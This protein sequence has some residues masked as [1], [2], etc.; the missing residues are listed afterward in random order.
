MSNNIYIGVDLGGTKIAIG[1]VNEA[2][3]AEQKK[4]L[5][6]HTIP[7]VF[8]K[9]GPTSDPAIREAFL[10]NLA[11]EISKVI[12]EA[13]NLKYHVHQ[14][15]GFGSPGLFQDGKIAPET[16]GQLGP[17]FFNYNI[18]EGLEHYLRTKHPHIK[19][20]VKNDALA[21]LAFGVHAL[22]QDPKLKKLF[23]SNNVGFIGP[24]T[25]L[26]G[27]FAHVKKLKD[28]NI[29]T[30]FFT[31]GHIFDILLDGKMAEELISGRFLRNNLGLSGKEV[32]NNLEK[33][34]AYIIEM[35]HNLGKLIAKIYSGKFEKPANH[36]QW[37]DKDQESVAGTQIFI[38]GGSIATKGDMGKI[39]R[40]SA[41]EYLEKHNIKNIKLLTLP[42]DSADAAILGAASFAGLTRLTN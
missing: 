6:K 3:Q 29:Q 22:A 7:T 23:L 12:T 37:S 13:Q 39:I 33:Y 5:L 30:E 36:I 25:G 34:Q 8:S 11:E 9:E 31:D 24:G 28:G 19:V 2:P 18:G 21:Q 17:A 35:G 20:N 10:E 40:S 26:G 32:A 1:A 41:K 14:T 15:I 4:I 38:L 16:A 27:G 42:S